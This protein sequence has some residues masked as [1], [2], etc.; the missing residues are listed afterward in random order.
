MNKLSNHQ[1][2]T[3]MFIFEIGSTTI[4]ALGIGAKQDAWIVILLALVIGLIFMWI[5]TELQKSFPDKN[6]IGIAKLILGN[7]IGTIVVFMYMFNLL[8]HCA[9]NTREFSE[10]LLMT[11]FP[12]TPMYIILMLF[13]GVSIHILIKG[14]EVLARLSEVIFYAIIISMI[15][16]YFLIYI[17]GKLDFSNLLPILGEGGKP[18]LKELPTIIVFPF[19]EVFVFSMYWNMVYEKEQLR[20]TGVKVIFYSG[21]LLC[22]SVI[23]DI[24]ALGAEYTEIATIPLVETIKLINIEGVI[25]NIDA[26]GVIMMFLGGFFKMTIYLNAINTIFTGIFRIKNVNLSLLCMGIFL[27]FFSILFEPN[28][29]YHKWMVNYDSPYY[30]IIYTNII[31]LILLLILFIKKKRIEF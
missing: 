8:W 13:I 21:V 23:I 27:L 10:L 11:L 1:L 25:S 3:L 30:A 5:Y 22:M 9:R 6:Y 20:K 24:C 2:F 19:G 31:P 18:V 26:I 29:A 12:T 4:F 14:I 15:V 17:S 16:I 7:K 28:Y